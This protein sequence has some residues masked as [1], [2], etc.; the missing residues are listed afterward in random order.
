MS[1]YTRPISSTIFNPF[2]FKPKLVFLTSLDLRKK[3]LSPISPFFF[4][5]SLY[6]LQQNS[7]LVP[8]DTLLPIFLTILLSP[9]VKPT[10]LCHDRK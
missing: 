6:Y 1:T 2:I 3:S 7:A 10:H 5:H 8:V 9:P 4:I